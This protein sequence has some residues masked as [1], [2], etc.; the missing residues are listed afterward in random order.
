MKKRLVLCTVTALSI[1]SLVACINPSKRNSQQSSGTSSS[2]NKVKKTLSSSSSEEESSNEK[3]QSSSEGKVTGTTQRVGSSDYGYIDIPSNW[4]RFR[5]VNGGD[6]IQYTDGSG[7]NIITLNALTE[8]KA[9][10][11]PGETFTANL[12][13]NRLA[14][15]WQDSQDVEKLWGAK[16]TVSGN[17]AYQLNVIMKSGQYVITW[18][19]QSGEKIYLIAF[20]GDKETLGTIIPYVEETWSLDKKG[21]AL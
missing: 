11:G 20:E 21:S 1:F 10:L 4:I 16:A 15:H 12:V 3:S 18:V 6:D 14:S 2:S 17:E 19:F 13:A 5:D 7:Y 9:K 8:E